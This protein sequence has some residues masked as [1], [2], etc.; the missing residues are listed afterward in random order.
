MTV[1]MLSV[2]GP[3]GIINYLQ[4]RVTL[5]SN[6]SNGNQ[7]R[8]TLLYWYANL[9]DNHTPTILTNLLGNHTSATYR[10]QQTLTYRIPSH[11]VHNICLLVHIDDR[12]FE[13]LDEL[14]P[15]VVK[16]FKSMLDR[17]ENSKLAY[18]PILPRAWWSPK[19][20][21]FGRRLDYIV[22][23]VLKRDHDIRVKA[24]S[25]Q[26]LTETRWN[27]K[28]PYDSTKQT[29][30]SFLET[31]NTHLN[32]WGYEA[33]VNEVSVP[34]MDSVAAPY[35]RPTYQPTNAIEMVQITRRNSTQQKGKRY[36]PYR[37]VCN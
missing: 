3:H 32:F 22:G 23:H 29:L 19:A 16:F 4:K 31:D 27:I 24:I 15:F 1:A 26:S 34:L 33:L 11:I 8:L 5:S 20:R 17:T 37:K 9:K 13:W 28:F 35:C 7:I 2:L 25:T 18:M 14:T 30:R 36:C 6:L 21:E 10:V 12:M